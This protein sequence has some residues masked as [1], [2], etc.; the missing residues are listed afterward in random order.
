MRTTV[1][2]AQITTVEDKIAG[3]LNLT[4]IVLLLLS[5]FAATAIYAVLPQKLQF[6]VYKIPLFIAEFFIFGFLSLRVRGRVVLNWI[7]VLS[8]YFF[9]PRYYIFSK[10]DPFLR[11]L[12]F[13]PKVAKS[14]A[15]KAKKA[16]SKSMKHKSITIDSLNKLEEILNPHRTKISLTFDKKGG[17]NAVWQVKG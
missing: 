2:P 7:F 10:N 13:L 11:E 6:T 4:Q 9:R 16:V 12:E 3:N 17:M 14:K 5:L 1:I 8:G 15:L